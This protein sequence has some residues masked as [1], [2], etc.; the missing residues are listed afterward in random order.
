M[1]TIRTV[2]HPATPER[3][4]RIVARL[5]G[6]RL[7]RYSSAPARNDADEHR[8]AAGVLART[9]GLALEAPES[10]GPRAWEHPIRRTDGGVGR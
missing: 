4:A 5:G 1:R 8:E 3:P 6:V 2:F 9:L 7:G 10:D